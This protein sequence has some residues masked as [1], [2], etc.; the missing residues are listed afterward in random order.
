MAAFSIRSSA[1]PSHATVV[2]FRGVE[3]ISTPYEIE[4]YFSLTGLDFVDLRDA[5]YS[6]A[7]LSI[8]LGGA[9]APF[10][11]GGVLRAVQLVR[12]L[13]GNALYL[14]KLV[15]QLWQL[16]LTR[17]SRVFTKKSIVE[18]IRAV[19]DEGG[20]ADYELRLDGSFEKED[21][22]C[23]YKESNL[24]FISRW[25]EREGLY[26]YFEQTDDGEKLVITNIK[27]SHHSLRQKPVRYFPLSGADGSSRQS[28]DDFTCTYNA[29]PASVKLDDYDYAKPALDVSGSAPV[30]PTGLGEIVS[31]GG[32][33][34]SASE[35][36]RIAQ[37][38]AEEYRAR[39]VVYVARG[40]AE[41]LHAGFSF[42]LEDHPNPSFNT[43]YLAT[44][45]K[46]FGFEPS[47]ISSW[48][49][50]V[51]PEFTDTYRVEVAAILADTQYRHG[52][53][54][55]WPQVNGYENAN[56]DGPSTS[57]YA[58]IDD[59]GRYLVKFKFDEGSLKEGKA[60]T[61]VRM[62]QPHD[63]PVEGHHFPLRKGVEVI[64]EFLG[65]DPDRPVIVGSVHNAVTPSVV[66]SSNHTQNVVRTGSL[67]HLVMEDASGAMWI[68]LYCPIFTSTL[69][70][71]HGEWNFNLT[72]QGSGQIQTTVNLNVDVDAEM[73]VDVVSHVDIDYHSTLHW[74]V[75]GLVK[76]HYHSTLDWDVDAAVKIDLHDTLS[77]HVAAKTDVKLDATFDVEVTGKATYLFK[78]DVGVTI[79]GNLDAH[80]K[81]NATLTTDG[82]K[83]ETVHGNVTETIDGTRNVH[84]KG[85][86]TITVD[87]PQEWIRMDVHKA[88]T[89]GATLDIFLGAKA[90]LQGAATFDAF[91]GVKNAVT[92][93]V[94][95]ELALTLHNSLTLGADFSIFAGLKA[96]IAAAL[97]LSLSAA[98][99][100]ITGAALNVTGPSVNISG[101]TINIAA[102]PCIT[103][104]AVEL[105]I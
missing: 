12:A 7:V 3:A 62:V 44:S 9:H 60:S 59:Q 100:S 94:S 27:S 43:T 19:L 47:L 97:Q 51:K 1:I 13:P 88:M 4:I 81:G 30:S 83:T 84:I 69:F 58:Q 76:V 95:N 72:T 18:I 103:L 87:A 73:K 85:A 71:G 42:D 92:I 70:L 46:H 57:Q 61:F 53:G 105:H 91:V 33:F 48:G 55:P 41:Q 23:Q 32:R 34:F 5:V 96:S 102:G 14:A 50:L 36:R 22:V 89:Y 6:K 26:Y 29:L 8:D 65:G 68:D 77:L 86:Q 56:V 25:M 40:A 49:A 11:F 78:A 66:T 64:C 52:E 10:T 15:P 39:E 80:V 38:R 54:T 79:D 98:N 104:S 101:P 90:T 2:G 35:G 93:G 63:G 16:S 24:T 82:N 28:F 74:D 45:V 20:V 17:H 31:Y 67:N 21:H 37:I 75:D 99:V